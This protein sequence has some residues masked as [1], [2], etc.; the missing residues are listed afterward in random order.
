MVA[1]EPSAES[2]DDE[3]IVELPTDEQEE[4]RENRRVGHAP[5]SWPRPSRLFSSLTHSYPHAQ[6]TTL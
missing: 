1:E 5:F 2:R 3:V 4:E 6:N